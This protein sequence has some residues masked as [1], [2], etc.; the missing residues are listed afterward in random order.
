MS[1]DDPAA[2]ILLVDDNANGLTARK[3]ILV[4]QGYSVE[5]ALSG[6]AAWE[7]FQTIHFD[8]VVT[9]YKMTGMDGIELIRL[10]RE[11]HSPARII[12]LS[13]YAARAGLTPEAIGADEL[14]AKSNKE[15]PELLRAVK[16]LSVRPR[17]RGVASAR[18]TGQAAPRR[19]AVKR[20]G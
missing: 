8:V 19:A 9:D 4:E 18:S 7:L 6:E 15:V 5:T 12:M 14:L 1:K 16:K 10:I 17:G 20:A 11:S 3:L 13:G 2:K